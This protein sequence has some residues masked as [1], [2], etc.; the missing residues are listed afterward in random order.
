MNEEFRRA[1]LLPHKDDLSSSQMEWRE[2]LLSTTPNDS[3]LM[4]GVECLYILLQKKPIYFLV[5]HTV[6][7]L[8]QPLFWVNLQNP[9]FILCLPKGLMFIFQIHELH[10]NQLPA[11]GSLFVCTSYHL[12]QALCLTYEWSCCSG[13]MTDSMTQNSWLAVILSVQSVL[14]F[15]SVAKCYLNTYSKCSVPVHRA[16]IVL[17]HLIR[18]KMFYN[19]RQ[20][21]NSGC[22]TWS[23]KVN[24]RFIK[25]VNG[26]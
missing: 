5:P 24:G 7:V 11:C 18:T 3:A 17:W 4:A 19:S 15:C 1:V 23:I 6:L 10:V 22:V 2:E 9:A 12:I 14:M 16:G 13:S 25:W 21:S 8:Y 26:M 20:F